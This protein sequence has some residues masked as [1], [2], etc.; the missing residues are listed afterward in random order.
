MSLQYLFCKNIA[1]I[2]ISISVLLYVVSFVEAAAIDENW[3]KYFALV[4]NTMDNEAVA[5]ALRHC[6][7]LSEN[8]YNNLKNILTIYRM[9][10]LMVKIILCIDKCNFE[11]LCNHI[12][13]H[14]KVKQLSDL[15]FGK[16][17]HN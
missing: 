1:C 10:Y 12:G 8:A 13:N 11:K 6:E 2:D 4:I 9:S 16:N 7:I 17:L 15:Y 5:R 14:E 3:E